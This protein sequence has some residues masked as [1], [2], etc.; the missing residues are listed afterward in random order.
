VVDNGDAPTGAADLA[1]VLEPGV[2]Y[3]RRWAEANDAVA[4]LGAEL[5]RLWLTELGARVRAEVSA[6][7]VGLVDLGR[8]SPAAARALAELLA[9]DGACSHHNVDQRRVSGSR[10]YARL[11]SSGSTWIGHFPA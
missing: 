11:T 1:F 4:L 8:V 6:A 3:P 7:G 2:P 5:D 10:K 9:T